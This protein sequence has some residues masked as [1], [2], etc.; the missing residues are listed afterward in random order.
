MD[1]LKKHKANNKIPTNKY[2]D[3]FSSQIRPIKIYLPCSKSNEN[4][5]DDFVGRERLMERLFN[6]LS[7][8]KNNKGLLSCNRIPRYG[9]NHNR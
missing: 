6:W 4:N 5:Y 3:K 2:N 9:Q 8:E 7:N 1:K